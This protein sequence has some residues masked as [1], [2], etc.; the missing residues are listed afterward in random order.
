MSDKSEKNDKFLTE[1]LAKVD[2]WLKD[3]KIPASSK[4][5]PVQTS[6]QRQQSVLP[7]EQAV[8]ILKNSRSFA[9]AECLCRT[10]YRRCD[11]PL[12]V[13]FMMNDAADRHVAEG[14]A[15]YI[16]FGE[17]RK[18]LQKANEAGLVHLTIFIPDFDLLAFC[19]CCPCC[20][21]DLQFLKL[22]GRDD[23]IAR[24]EY[25]AITQEDLCVNCEVCVDR[26][27]F[28][29]RVFR[30]KKLC[31]DARNC[32][33]CGLCV[34]SCPANAIVMKRRTEAGDLSL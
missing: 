23:L 24:S 20:C 12:E 11:N 25:K 13:C 5:I 31:W 29:A 3:E 8:D 19:S 7:T 14:K 26:C 2:V 34:T 9:L 30:G 15:R 28:G 16:P 10:H 27:V 21:H 22:Y 18:I 4:V 33:G 17:A 32:Y 6:L 1:R